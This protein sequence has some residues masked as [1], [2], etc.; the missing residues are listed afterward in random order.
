MPHRDIIIYAQWQINEYTVIFKDKAGVVLKEET[1]LAY[2]DATPPLDEDMQIEHY[3]FH[4]WDKNYTSVLSDIVCTPVY[5]AIKYDITYNLNEGELPSGAPLTYTIEGGV[6]L[7]TPIRTGYDFYG[8]YLTED[9]TGTPVTSIEYG[10]LPGFTVYARF[11]LATYDVYLN[12]TV[13]GVTYD[14]FGAP[15]ENKLRITYQDEYTLPRVLVPNGYFFLGWYSGQNGTGTRFADYLGNSESPWSHAGNITLYAHVVSL[16]D[17][18]NINISGGAVGFD[19]STYSGAEVILNSVELYLGGDLVASIDEE[20]LEATSFSFADL[21]VESPYEIKVTYTYTIPGVEG[22]R[23]TYSSFMVKITDDSYPETVIGNSIAEIQV[24][25]DVF[26]SLTIDS[27]TIMSG[28]EV[29]EY[30]TIYYPGK[31]GSMLSDGRY[32]IYILD[33]VMNTEYQVIVNYRYTLNNYAG[34]YTSE[35]KVDFTTGTSIPGVMFPVASASSA[36][37]D[38]GSDSNYYYYTYNVSVSFTN[39]YLENNVRLVSWELL[40]NSA[41]VVGGN[42]NSLVSGGSTSWSTRISRGYLS[43]GSTYQIKFTYTYDLQ[44]GMGTQTGVIVHTFGVDTAD[45]RPNDCFVA[46][47]DVLMA[48]GSIKDIENV[49]LGDMVMVWDFYTGSYTASPVILIHTTLTN[50][51]FYLEFANG[52]RVGVGKSHGF[53]VDGEFVTVSYDNADSFIGKGFLYEE[54]GEIFYT[55]L[56]SVDRPD[57]NVMTYALVT[58]R[59]YNHFAD[60][61]LSVIPFM[62]LVN[63]FEYDGL[64]YDE[65]LMLRDLETYGYLDYDGWKDYVTEEQFYAFAGEYMNVAMG[66]GRISA[67]D[68]VSLIMRYFFDDEITM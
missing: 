56:L 45:D 8:W 24:G 5:E 26:A 53:Y 58:A 66:K 46:G 20:D 13:K 47:T 52:K 14:I 2:E 28:E 36:R 30:A 29:V 38:D 50:E 23:T 19:I 17:F 68:F 48:D 12:S 42:I 32:W 10:T 7:P 57:D 61:F 35:I 59:H 62:G 65:E 43:N 49:K 33:L 18:A 54:N 9:L 64:K 44:D 16:L 39:V 60:G 37:V 4:G 63:V 27:I 21:F 31:A 25:N 22:E 40:K 55:E 1:L 15:D 51:L 34:E 11:E 67:E 3:I 41:Y 6:K